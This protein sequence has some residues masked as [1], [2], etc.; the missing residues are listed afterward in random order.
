MKGKTK[1]TTIGERIREIFD[2]KNMTITQFAELLHCDPSNV[3]NMF[4]RKKIDISLL[5]EV[6][7]ILNHNFIEEICTK[8]EF[9][10]DMF[11][12]KTSIVFEINNIDAQALEN[13]IKTIKLLEIKTIREIKD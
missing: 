4:R 1:E 10:E 8:H 3:H 11:P 5:C 13:L 9:S 6:S 12:S 2:K 7:K